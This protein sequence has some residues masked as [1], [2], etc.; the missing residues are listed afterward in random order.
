MAPLQKYAPVASHLNPYGPGVR[1]NGGNASQRA[2]G[3]WGVGER[4]NM[5]QKATHN[6]LIN[7]AGQRLDKQVKA[8]P[9][10][11]SEWL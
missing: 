3:H 9:E 5:Q 11:A 8:L 6:E 7:S 10:N 4:K 2:Q 1:K